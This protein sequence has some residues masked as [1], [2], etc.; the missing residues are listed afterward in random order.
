MNRGNLRNAAV[1][2]SHADNAVAASVSNF[3]ERNRRAIGCGN[4]GRNIEVELNRAA[5]Q[6]GRLVSCSDCKERAR[7]NINIAA[8]VIFS[9][10]VITRACRRNRDSRC[11][12]CSSFFAGFFATAGRTKAAKSNLRGIGVNLDCLD[13]AR[14]RSVFNG[15]ESIFADGQIC[16]VRS[17]IAGNNS[18]C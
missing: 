17:V 13:I 3:R 2:N 8:N 4:I 6:A 12:C 10:S 14:R 11:R 18:R 5:Y 7:R 1:N 15:N 9:R 16:S